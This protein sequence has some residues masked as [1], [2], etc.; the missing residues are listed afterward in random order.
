MDIV[1]FG[2]LLRFAN[3]MEER[4]RKS[5]QDASEKIGDRETKELL[6]VLASEKTKNLVVLQKLYN[7]SIWSDMDVGVQEPIQGLESS[8][9]L[10]ENFSG[11]NSKVTFL[12]TAIA[13]EEQAH[14]FYLDS[15]SQIKARRPAV[16][17][18]LEKLA[19]DSLE[20]KS[21]LESQQH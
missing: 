7:D 17:R 18:K 9:Y 20:R 14:R 12:K 16:A 8:D 5:Y 15:S 4:H 19:K 10:N 3:E 13:W 2:A 11:F 1:T 21:Q 6:S